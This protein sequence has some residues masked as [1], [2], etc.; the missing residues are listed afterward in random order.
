MNIAYSKSLNF[1]APRATSEKLAVV[2]GGFSA[3]E[4]LEELRAFGGE[5]WGINGAAKWCIDRGIDASLFSCT[6]L[7]QQMS[8]ISKAVLSY[9]CASETF[10]GLNGAEIYTFDRDGYGPTSGCCIPAL[11]FSAGF[12]EVHFFGCEGSYGPQTHIYQDAPNGSDMIVRVNGSE[13]RTNIGYFMQS[14]LL[15]RVIREAPNYCKDRS[16]GLLAALVADPDGWDV[17]K[18]PSEMKEAA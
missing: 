16:G 6:P 1:P 17:I 14:E 7:P 18:L 4:H 15:A 9:E 11:A 2:G 8:G 10:R 13:Y 12:K 3:G 5:V